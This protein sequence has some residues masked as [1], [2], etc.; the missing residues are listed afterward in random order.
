MSDKFV[1]QNA[2]IKSME[3]KL[4]TSQHIQRLFECA[5]LDDAMKL[6]IEI[7]FGVNSTA[8][9]NKFDTLFLQE[10]AGAVAVLRDFNVDGILDAFLLENDYHNLKAL[11]KAMVS[12]ESNPVLMPHG[13][14]QIEQLKVGLSGD[15]SDLPSEMSTAIHTL[16]K[17]ISEEKITPHTIDTIVDVA[18]YHDIFKRIKGNSSL[19]KTYFV[20]KVD[21]LNILTFLRCKNLNLSQKFFADSFVDGGELAQEFFVAIYESATEVLKDKCKYTP[22]QDIVEVAVDSKNLVGFEVSIDNALLKIWK[23]ESSEMFSE[24]PIVS[25][26][27]SKLTQ[28]KIVKLIV[29]GIKNKVDRDLIK[30]RMRDIYA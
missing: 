26:Y 20:R 16:E 8:E 14:Y 23:D 19:Q 2:R 25:F 4:M 28:L 3:C 21:Y 27:F 29:A 7:G 30:E 24:A 13:V 17:L 6:L 11:L 10:E 5:N 22:Y 1:F 18:K 15:A 12:G 9:N